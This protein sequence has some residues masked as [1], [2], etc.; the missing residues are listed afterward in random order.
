MNS[1]RNFSLRQGLMIIGTLS[2]AV[3]LYLPWV[4]PRNPENPVISILIAGME[5]GYTLIDGVLLVP[6]LFVLFFAGQQTLSRRAALSTFCIGEIYIFAL[7]YHAKVLMRPP[8][9]QD[10]GAFVTGFGGLLLIGAGAARLLD[11]E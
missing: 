2:A 8:F 3:G 10:I 7:I 11:Q 1:L 4:K 6:G 5:T 9:V